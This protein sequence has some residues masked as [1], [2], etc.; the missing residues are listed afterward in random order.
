[1][2]RYGGAPKA[3]YSRLSAAANSLRAVSYASMAAVS[4]ARISPSSMAER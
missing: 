2:T 3:T 1:M 4:S